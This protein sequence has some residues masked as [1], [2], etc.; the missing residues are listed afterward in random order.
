MDFLLIQPLSLSLLDPVSAPFTISP[1]R[2]APAHPLTPCSRLR[3]HVRGGGVFGVGMD[4]VAG[5]QLGC[6]FKCGFLSNPNGTHQ[7]WTT[8]RLLPTA[9][10]EGEGVQRWGCEWQLEH[11]CERERL[12]DAQ[13]RWGCWKSTPAPASIFEPPS[14]PITAPDTVLNLCQISLS[15]PFPSTKPTPRTTPCAF[16]LHSPTLRS[17]TIHRSLP[18]PASAPNIV[19]NAP[20]ALSNPVHQSF[21]SSR[22]T[23]PFQNSRAADPALVLGT[24][25]A[26]AHRLVPSS[27]PENG[28]RLTAS[29]YPLPPAQFNEQSRALPP[30]AVGGIKGVDRRGGCI[31]G[32]WLCLRRWGGEGEFAADGEGWGFGECGVGVATVSR[33]FFGE[34]GTAGAW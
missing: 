25:R 12:L 9:R 4:I 33:R 16:P 8:S 21:P 34:G 7:T 23:A 29:D 13:R 6:G 19:L 3:V 31:G 2:L 28:P 22:A 27:A 32:L 17:S 11:K 20:A 10:L 15:S 18:L 26:P 14:A 1:T 5:I 30:R 24:V